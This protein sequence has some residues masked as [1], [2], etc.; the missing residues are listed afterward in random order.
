MRSAQAGRRNWDRC[1][2]LC[3]GTPGLGFVWGL[4]EFFRGVA[5]PCFSFGR[6]R[7]REAEFLQANGTPLAKSSLRELIKKRTGAFDVLSVAVQC[8]RL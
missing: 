1:A 3:L 7:R 8:S 5:R 4:P 6:Y 2:E